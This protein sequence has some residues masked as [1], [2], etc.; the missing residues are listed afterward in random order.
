MPKKPPKI[1]LNT[2]LILNHTKVII[3]FLKLVWICRLGLESSVLPEV[4]RTL[5]F[6]QAGWWV[7]EVFIRKAVLFFLW[8]VRS[9]CCQHCAVLCAAS[10]A[11]LLVKGQL[12]NLRVSISSK[13]QTD[14]LDLC[15]GTCRPPSGSGRL[16]RKGS[17]VCVVGVLEICWAACWN[18]RGEG[19]P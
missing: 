2:I 13:L 17:A 9:R 19:I 6:V 8:A 7:A 15:S 1:C 18:A 12:L 14:V 3:E 16:K 4:Q 11:L 10:W 5:R